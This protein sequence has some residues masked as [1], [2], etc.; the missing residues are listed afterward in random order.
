MIELK[1]CPV[2]GCT[3]V[4]HHYHESFI[5]TAVRHTNEVGCGD[6]PVCVTTSESAPITLPP[7]TVLGCTMQGHH[8]HYGESVIDWSG[9]PKPGCLTGGCVTTA[10]GAEER[11]TEDDA[12]KPWFTLAVEDDQIDHPSHYEGF[13]C[14]HCGGPIECIDVR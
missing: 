10:I 1:P 6:D 13:E 11:P 4:G 2:P 12:P 7:C 3:F 8:R 9:D 14:P 5:G